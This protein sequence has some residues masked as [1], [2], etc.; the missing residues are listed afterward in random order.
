MNDIIS[1]LFYS[2]YRRFDEMRRSHQNLRW[3]SI[4]CANESVSP[5]MTRDCL[6]PVS[7]RSFRSEATA[8]WP[9]FG[10]SNNI[11]HRLSK[12]WTKKLHSPGIPQSNEKWIL[13]AELAL[14]Q[15][16]RFC[17]N[18]SRICVTATNMRVW[19]KERA[20]WRI[21]GVIIRLKRPNPNRQIDGLNEILSWHRMTAWR[22]NQ[23]AA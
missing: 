9:L 4:H 3:F 1:L 8:P 19:H 10:Q 17:E 22:I 5:S 6:Q 14:M 2:C 20:D 11:N 13:F 23:L 18:D 21:N 7:I 12:I 15:M 16:S